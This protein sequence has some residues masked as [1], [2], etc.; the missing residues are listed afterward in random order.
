MA[1]Y[2]NEADIQQLL[3]VE[4]CIEVMDDLFQ[5]EAR[6]LVDNLPRRRMR[7]GQAGFTLMGG[8]VLGS[9]AYGVRHSNLTLLYST[10]DGKLEAVLRSGPIAWIRTGAASG[11]ATRYMARPDASVVG[12]IGAGRQAVT[13]LEAVCAVRPVQ[14]VKVF[15]RTEE[16]RNQFAAEMREH[17]GVEVQPVTSATA[18]VKGSQVLVT[19]T[20]AREPVFDGADLEPGTHINAAGSNHVTRREVDQATIERSDVIAVDNLEQARM[21]CGE[22]IAAA[23]RGGFLWSRAAELCDVVAARVDGRPYL[24]AVTLFESQGI[25]TEDIAASAYVLKK[26]RERGIGEELPF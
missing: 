12:V 19:I 25:G 26:A 4:E 23:E 9:N 8:A 11:L 2:L 18:C 20:N 1:L 16:R 3:T 10:A 5:Q 15:S 7:Y 6:G 14:L 24:D 22:L 13:Q 17:L 21:E